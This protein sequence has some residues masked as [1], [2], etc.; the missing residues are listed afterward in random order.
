HG[1]GNG[2]LLPYVMRYNAAVRADEIGVVGMWLA[3]PGGLKSLDG[4]ADPA[5]RQVEQL[6][7][8]IGI[9]TRLRDLGVTEDMLPG[10]AAKAFSI[11]RLMRVNPRMPQN[12]GEILDI[13]RTAF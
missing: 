10:F 1:A 7:R 4:G 13:Y 9:P 6:R 3:G 11:K 5:I 8:D 2:L 12:E